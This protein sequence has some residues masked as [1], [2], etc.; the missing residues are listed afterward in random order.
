MKI[1][2]VIPAIDLIGGNAVRLLHGD[3]SRATTY[4]DPVENAVRF[5][6]AGMRRLHIVDLDGARTGVPH[7][8]EVLRRIAAETD[9]VIDYGGGIRT[10]EGL[11][12]VF[13]AGASMVTVGSVAFRDPPM[14]KGWLKR[15]GAGRFIFAADVKDGAVALEGWRNSSRLTVSEYVAP[16]LQYGEIQVMCTSI[17]RDGAL[18]GP[19]FDCYTGLKKMSPLSQVAE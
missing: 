13:E 15:F 8:L 2:E 12:S 18:T 11:E 9:L 10:I 14:V 3:F 7:H 1:F 6:N 17:A 5:K 16:Y 4:G 19:D